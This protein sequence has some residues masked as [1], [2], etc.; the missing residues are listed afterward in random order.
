[1]T[2]EDQTLSSEERTTM[3][4]QDIGMRSN[5]PARSVVGI[6]DLMDQKSVESIARSFMTGATESLRS[7]S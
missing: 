5:T 2:Q 6:S 3:M 1:M 4:A 7:R